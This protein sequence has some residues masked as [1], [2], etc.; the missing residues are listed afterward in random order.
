MINFV[1]SGLWSLWSKICQN[2]LEGYLW[3]V[4]WLDARIWTEIN[5]LTCQLVLLGDSL[6]MKSMFQLLIWYCWVSLSL[7]IALT[8]N[9]LPLL[10]WMFEFMLVFQKCE[11][12]YQNVYSRIYTTKNSVITFLSNPLTYLLQ[13]ILHLHP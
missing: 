5:I 12:W 8:S 3:T 9:N 10:I 13:P 4:T 1:M 7:N 6:L 11:S 2:E